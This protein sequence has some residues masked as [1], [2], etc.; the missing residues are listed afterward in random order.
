MFYILNENKEVVSIGEDAMEWARQFEGTERR[1]DDTLIV[2]KYNTR[3]S[4]VFL[5][6][7][8]RFGTDQDQLPV[9][10]ETMT[11]SNNPDLN[12]YQERYCTYDEAVKGHNR[13]VEFI[14]NDIP[15]KE[16]RKTLTFNLTDKLNQK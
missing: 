3:I 15:L 10:F 7:D 1:V 11:F 4:T 13:I 16:A 6:L 14:K 8:H 2:E 9:V 12:E 5:G